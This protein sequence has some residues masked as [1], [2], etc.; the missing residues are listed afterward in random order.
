MLATYATRRQIVL[1]ALAR[2]GF[3]CSPPGGAFYA[4]FDVSALGLH[5]YELSR[6]LLEQAGVFLYPG[7]GFGERWS[8]HMRLAWLAPEDRLSEALAR[9]ERWLRA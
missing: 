4:F 3:R 5:S 9:I 6:R 1:D 2:M 8:T 7:S